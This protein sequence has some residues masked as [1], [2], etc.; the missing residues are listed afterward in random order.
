MVGFMRFD[1]IREAGTGN[2][3]GDKGR[4]ITSVEEGLGEVSGVGVEVIWVTA[5]A[6]HPDGQ[7]VG[8]G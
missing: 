4:G 7:R 8:N 2:L 6:P 1:G 5:D 3:L